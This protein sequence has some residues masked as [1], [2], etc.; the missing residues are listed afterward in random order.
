MDIASEYWERLC[1]F[2]LLR[3]D[4][5]TSLSL[6]VQCERSVAEGCQG[7]LLVLTHA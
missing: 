6:P 7:Y 2:L 4:S 1:L 5:P 3:K